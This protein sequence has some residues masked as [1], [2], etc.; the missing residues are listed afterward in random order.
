MKK[1]IALAAALLLSA[2]AV[3]AENA[4]HF[5][6]AIPLGSVTL[7]NDAEFSSTAYDFYADWT[8]IADGGFTFG[9]NFAGGSGS[10]SGDGDFKLDVSNIA[11]GTGFGYSFIHNEKMTLSL[12]GDLGLDFLI[13]SENIAGYDYN[14]MTVAFYIGPKVSFTYKLLKHFGVFV[15]AGLY[16]AGGSFIKENEYPME[17]G[18]TNVHSDSVDFTGVIFRPEFGVAIPL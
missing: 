17:H 7:E 1:L 16:Y 8:H 14:Y 13:G 15:N 2:S 10:L 11:F 12:T 6:L 9:F 18:G 5:G 3:F 4:F